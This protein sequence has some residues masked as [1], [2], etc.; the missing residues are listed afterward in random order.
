MR[1]P[2][3]EECLDKK[4]IVF[5]DEIDFRAHMLQM[6]PDQP[7]GRKIQVIVQ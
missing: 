4:F 7:I 6:H 1:L 3:Q 5:A 2:P